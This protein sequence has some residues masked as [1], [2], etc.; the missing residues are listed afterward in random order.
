[1]YKLTLHIGGKDETF[2]FPT[3]AARDTFIKQLKRDGHDIGPQIADDKWQDYQERRETTLANGGVVIDT[4]KEDGVTKM[5]FSYSE[6]AYQTMLAHAREK[7]IT[8]DALIE[9]DMKEYFPG[10]TPTLD[11]TPLTRQQRRQKERR[12]RKHPE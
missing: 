8:V 10:N 3:L 11:T 9:Q 1:M 6:E 7:D 12:A 5:K 4:Y 2:T